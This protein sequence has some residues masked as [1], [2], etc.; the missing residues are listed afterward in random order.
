[1]KT[2]YATFDEMVNAAQ[3]AIDKLPDCKLSKTNITEKQKWLQDILNILKNK[4]YA[5]IKHINGNYIDI[6]KIANTYAYAS[7]FDIYNSINLFDIQSSPVQIEELK[8]PL[9]YYS[10]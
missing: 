4:K 5:R 9:L 3:K 10:R 8:Y 2:F 6:S 7:F 1:M